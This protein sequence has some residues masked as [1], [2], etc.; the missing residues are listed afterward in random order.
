MLSCRRYGFNACSEAKTEPQPTGA[1]SGLSGTSITPGVG[2]P[3]TKRRPSLAA[4]SVPVDTWQVSREL[5]SLLDAV[6]VHV[7]GLPSPRRHTAAPAQSLSASDSFGYSGDSGRFD[8]SGSLSHEASGGSTSAG[9]G[10]AARVAAQG[11]HM[12]VSGDRFDWFAATVF[13]L[14][15]NSEKWVLP[16]GW[17]RV[18][19]VS[20]CVHPCLCAVVCVLVLVP[21]CWYR[22]C[23]T[24]LQVLAQRTDPVGPWLW[25]MLGMSS[26]YTSTSAASDVTSMPPP[27]LALSHAVE[28]TL[29]VVEP[30]VMAAFRM[31]GQS[32][33]HVCHLV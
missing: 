19:L 10:V 9:D 17:L 27:L 26:W 7:L 1:T 31:C 20:A 2:L 8:V 25:P 11:W 18:V 5:A 15:G 28:A 22:R 33:S 23:F 24:A 21:L 4:L 13:L 6:H 3:P 14:V 16:H 32:P 30:H 12:A 29:L